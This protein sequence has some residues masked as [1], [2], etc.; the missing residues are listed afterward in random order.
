MRE[1]REMLPCA[2]LKESMTSHC[3]PSLFLQ[4][5]WQ[6]RQRHAHPK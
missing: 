2:M 1:E 6:G 3:L 4:S 5:V